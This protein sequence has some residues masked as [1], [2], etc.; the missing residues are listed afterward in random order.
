M[1]LSTEAVECL[2]LTLEG[3]DNVKSGDR[4]AASM[5]AVSD[6]ITNDVAEEG[7]EHGAGLVVHQARDA[8]DAA[9]TSQTTNR[10]FGDALDVVA[11]D[12]AVALG[13]SLAAFTSF[14]GHSE[15]LLRDCIFRLIVSTG[16]SRNT[17]SPK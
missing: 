11:Q 9:T 5:L 6:G 3:V 12:L 16:F 17:P 15:E 13:T 4:L 2:A 14:A 7:L 8:F 10:R 1:H